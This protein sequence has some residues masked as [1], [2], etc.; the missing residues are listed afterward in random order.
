MWQMGREGWGRNG[1]DG[2]K[3]H[4][5]LRKRGDGLVEKKKKKANEPN[6]KINLQKHGGVPVKVER[7]T[8]RKLPV[9]L[10]TVYLVKPLVLSSVGKSDNCRA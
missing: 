6:S 2:T 7:E 3:D 10:G 5:V 1:K 8:I 4:T 9:A